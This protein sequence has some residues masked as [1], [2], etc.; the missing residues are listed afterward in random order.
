MRGGPKAASEAMI[1]QEKGGLWGGLGGSGSGVV[2]LFFFPN[3]AA[4]GRVASHGGCCW[5]HSALEKNPQEK[6]EEE[7][8][9]RTS[10]PEYFQKTVPPAI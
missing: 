5:T 6:K 3:L 4:R 1:P 2:V 7:E 10:K 9:W 8:G